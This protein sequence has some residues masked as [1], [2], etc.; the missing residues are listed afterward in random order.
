MEPK[1]RICVLAT[2]GTIACVHGPSGLRPGLTGERLLGFVPHMAELA[3]VDCV[4]LMALD[5]SNLLPEHW[6]RMAEAVAERHGDYDGFVILHGTDTMAYSAGALFLMLEHMD[7]PV[8][9]TG[10]QLPME[11]VGTDAVQ[12]LLAALH[13]AISGRAGVFLAF[14]GK[15]YSAG[16]VRK[17]FSQQFEGFGSIQRSAM[18]IFKGGQYEWQYLPSEP[19]GEF[20]LVTAMDDRVAVLKLVP[21]TSPSLLKLMV[22]AG[23]HAI[24]IEGYGVGG[25]PNGDSPKDFLPMLSYAAE[26]GALI[27]CTT[28]CVYDGTHLDTYE[29]GIMAV[30]QGAVSGGRLSLELLVPAVMLAIAKGRERSGLEEYLRE[31]ERRIFSL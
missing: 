7:C 20:R 2:G 14:A 29:M 15:L 3:E 21:G 19:K 24:I 11:A 26:Q 31:T 23:Y 4:E 28:Q 1:K 22:D 6:Q 13:A 25:V 18:A 8:V 5:S 17:L 30:R 12:N 16:D 9:F 10:A 27:V